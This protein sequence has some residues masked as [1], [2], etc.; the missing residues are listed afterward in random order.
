M[1]KLTRAFYERDTLVVAR[2]LL[3]K[4][5]VHVVD[6]LPLLCKITDVEAYTGILDKACHA[7]GGRYTQRTQPLWG[8]AG[9]SYIYLI[10]GMYHLLNVVTEPEGQPCA[11][12]IRGV[13]PIE[14]LD[15]ISFFRY[16]KP[17]GLLNKTQIKNLSNGPGKVSKAMKLDHS[18][19]NLDLLGN[20]LFICDAPNIEELTVLKGKRINIDYAQEAKDF[21]YRF[22][23]E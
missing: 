14:P 21:L 16:Q 8:A 1:R 3:G 2:E 6:D 5:L 15:T 23:I 19:N 22:Y 20:E 7:Y 13:L 4:T 18:H 17:Y 12:L 11:V 9:F 10:Y